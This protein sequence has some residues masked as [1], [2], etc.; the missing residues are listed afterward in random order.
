MKLEPCDTLSLPCLMVVMQTQ[1]RAPTKGL[2]SCLPISWVPFAELA[3]V[4]KPIACLYLYFPCVFGTTLAASV[5]DPMVGSIDLLKVN[6]ILLVGSFLVRCVGCSWNDIVDQDFDRKVLRTRLRPLARRAIATP[7][8]LAFTTFQ[9]LIGLVLVVLLLP[10]ECLYYSIPSILLTG[11]YPY[12]KRFTNFPQVIL[13]CVSSW[14][15]VMA[16]P[17]LELDIMSSAAAMKASGCL[18]LSCISWT[19][20]YDTVYAAQD[21]KDD[22][23]AG[24]GSPVVRHREHTRILLTGAALVQIAMLCFT[25]VCMGASAAYFI[26]TCLAT[27]WT[28]GRMVYRVN[29]DDPNDCIGWFK[30]SCFYTG[31][32]ISSGFIAEYITRRN[33]EVSLGRF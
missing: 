29:L 5:S 1:Y 6:L 2:M 31:L 15:V 33:T 24:V 8:A 22:V 25:G 11:L 27:T 32:V 19:M 21:V 3:R 28:L 12:G 30:N 10:V 26:C 9:V 16:F 17:A 23:K 14:G 20:V 4:D 18:F 7:E 13:G